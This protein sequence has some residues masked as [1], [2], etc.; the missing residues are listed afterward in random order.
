M[1]SSDAV[2]IDMTSD[3]G[4]M[5]AGAKERDLLAMANLMMSFQT[6]NLFG[7]IYKTMSNDWP[8]GLAHEVVLYNF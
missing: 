1:P 8:A 2:V 4:K 3:T 7:L 5:I 6:E